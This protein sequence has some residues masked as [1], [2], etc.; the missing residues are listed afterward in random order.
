[1]MIFRFAFYGYAKFPEHVKRR[2]VELETP[3]DR[4]KVEWSFMCQVCPLLQKIATVVFFSE[5]K[6]EYHTNDSR[7]T[8]TKGDPLFLRRPNPDHIGLIRYISVSFS[9]GDFI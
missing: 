1:M 3:W 4:D 8:R 9:D 7:T 6:F 5:T 2:C